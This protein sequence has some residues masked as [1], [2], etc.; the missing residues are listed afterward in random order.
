MA[1]LNPVEELDL[2]HE[3]KQINVAFKGLADLVGD[4]LLQNKVKLMLHSTYCIIVMQRPKINSLF[5]M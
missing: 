1:N 3:V 4:A 5:H 2:K